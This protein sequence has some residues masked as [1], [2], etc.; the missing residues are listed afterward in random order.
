MRHLLKDIFYALI[1]GV[2][3]LAVLWVLFYALGVVS[4]TLEAL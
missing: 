3:A 4:A 2:I 1:A